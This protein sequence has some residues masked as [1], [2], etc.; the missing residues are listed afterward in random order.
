MKTFK[1]TFHEKTILVTGATGFVGQAL[2]N[3]LLHYNCKLRLIVRPES[4]HKVPKQWR[5]NFKVK[6]F[7]GNV[8][9]ANLMAKACRHSD[10]ILHAAAKVSDWGYEQ[11]YRDVMEIG[12]EHLFNEA[13]QHRIPVV[14]IS[15]GAVYG[16]LSAACHEDTA[17]G[18]PH[19]LY[20]KY[21]QIQEMIAE[22]HALTDQLPVIVLRPFNIIG[23]GALWVDE[24]AKAINKGLPSMIGDGH[25][26]AG[27][28][29]VE[30]VVHA[31]LLSSKHLLAYDSPHYDVYNVCDDYNVTWK[32]Y[33]T[34]LCHAIGK[35]KP[36]AITRRMAQLMAKGCGLLWS[37]GRLFHRMRSRPPV[38][39]ES[40]NILG[41]DLVIPTDRIK[42]Q[43]HYEPQKSFARAMDEIKPYLEKKF[44]QPKHK[45]TQHSRSNSLH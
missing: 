9:D 45:N 2:V 41:G 19:S 17:F 35:E 7:I 23:P 25:G 18:K 21:K 1:K 14:L 37:L 5:D 38:T 43:L 12:T 3:K 32:E 26:N 22:R 28:V 29:H 27:L 30:N 40:V 15:S 36:K 44:C 16:N 11:E 8:N 39:E 20:S 31:I 4:L 10:I 13:S 24:A 6:L 42:N 34:E 33:L